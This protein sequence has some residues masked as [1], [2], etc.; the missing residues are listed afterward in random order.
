MRRLPYPRKSPLTFPIVLLSAI[1]FFLLVILIAGTVAQAAPAPAGGPRLGG[2][3]LPDGSLVGL[4][5][6][7]TTDRARW[8][9]EMDTLESSSLWV[10]VYNPSVRHE[11]NQMELTF[12]WEVPV[13]VTK[14]VVVDGEVQTRTETVW[15]VTDQRTFFV[16]APVR[17]VD[18]TELELPKKDGERLTITAGARNTTLEQLTHK[19]SPVLVK[20]PR[21]VVQDA[22]VTLLQILAMALAA[23]A[24]G[25]VLSR[26]LYNKAGRHVPA[27]GKGAWVGGL[28]VVFLIGL[29]LWQTNR[30]GLVLSGSTPPLAVFS[31]VVCF[32]TLQVWRDEPEKD[33]YVRIHDSVDSDTPRHS[34]YVRYIPHGEDPHPLS[35]DPRHVA[36]VHDDWRNFAWRVFMRARWYLELPETHR[37]HYNREK[38]PF[39]RLY[40]L[41]GAKPFETV[42]EPH[43]DWFPNGIRFPWIHIHRRGI[44]RAPVS[45]W[46]QKEK[47]VD[48][49]A[50][51]KE[52]QEMARQHQDLLVEAGTLRAEIK[53]GVDKRAQELMDKMFLAI[54]AV[55]TGES[56]EAAKKRHAEMK[57][58]TEKKSVPIA[59]NGGQ[60]AGA[61]VTPPPPP[62][63]A[64]P[65]PVPATPATSGGQA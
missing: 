64:P 26:W 13:T 56:F 37:W 50:N 1:A 61:P 17:Q 58:A 36:I 38:G 54:R 27:L 44:T 49:L 63:G 51:L 4:F 21:Q 41:D 12:T 29:H 35:D 60:G 6:F 7:D 57:A 30:E 34:A 32:F 45:P 33:L 5:T 31:V 10:F 22:W 20:L 25:V 65:V 48:V 55:S 24:V 47:V 52:Q 2:G 40:I 39:R 8:L 28:L 59:E 62:P 42:E 46:A 16:S 11:T 15:N 43:I 18:Y 23:A 53:S 19:T 3:A 9:S 14:E